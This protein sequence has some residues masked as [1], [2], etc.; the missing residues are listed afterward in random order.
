MGFIKSTS[1]ITD[2]AITVSNLTGGTNGKIVR[3]N[4]NNTVTDAAWTDTASQL[5]A[6]LFKQAGV[7]YASG[8]IPGIGG[9]TAGSAYFLGEFGAL[10]TNPPTPSSTVRVL[11]IGFALNTSDLLLRPGIPI[12]G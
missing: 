4:G 5:N 7:Y 2:R 6:V 12:S 8:V 3:V 9:L 11:F 10:T 1:Q